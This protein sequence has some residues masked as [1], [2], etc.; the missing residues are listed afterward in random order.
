[1]EMEAIHYNE[2]GLLDGT[3]DTGPS[4]CLSQW[5]NGR[6]ISHY[7]E[8]GAGWSIR[9]VKM[10]DSYYYSHK[11]I[12]YEK[13]QLREE[14]YGYRYNG[15][16]VKAGDIVFCAY[17]ERP[18][19]RVLE[20]TERMIR[21][22]VDNVL[23]PLKVITSKVLEKDIATILDTDDVEALQELLW[24]E[25]PSLEVEDEVGD[26]VR[27]LDK[28]F[29]CGVSVIE[30]VDGD[31]DVDVEYAE[32]GEEGE[33]DTNYINASTYITPYSVAL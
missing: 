30:D 6:L 4:G 29:N 28:T 5:Y 19:F 23:F 17:K 22:S 1:M 10:W 25:V 26:E 13:K 14:I 20:A 31:G 12:D 9:V 15:S 7:R 21:D 8:M 2:N 18:T 3:V 16:A 33:E 24:V 27:F 32:E 11:Q